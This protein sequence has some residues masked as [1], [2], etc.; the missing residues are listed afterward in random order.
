MDTQKENEINHFAAFFGQLLC[1][2]K[3]HDLKLKHQPNVYDG[4]S[5]DSKIEVLYSR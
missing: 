2:L 5:R 1:G 4:T 3:Y